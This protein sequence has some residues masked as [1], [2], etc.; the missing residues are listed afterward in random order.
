VF[1]NFVFPLV[2]T[3]SWDKPFLVTFDSVHDIVPLFFLNALF[4][5]GQVDCVQASLLALVNG[6]AR[7]HIARIE[8]NK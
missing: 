4:P 3:V 6:R 1:Y 8:C 5:T 7:V 2:A